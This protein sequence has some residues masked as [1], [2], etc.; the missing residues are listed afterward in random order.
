MRRRLIV[1][2]VSKEKEE[3]ESE[4]GDRGFLYVFSYLLFYLLFILF[5]H[6][7]KR[8]EMDKTSISSLMEDSC[9]WTLY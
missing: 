4:Q 6:F 1:L 9:S 8:L 5:L 7:E 2:L 3:V